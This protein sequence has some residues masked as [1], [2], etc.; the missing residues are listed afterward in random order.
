MSEKVKLAI[1]WH[2]HQPY[3]RDPLS[4]QFEMPWVRLHALRD[5]WGMAAMLEEFPR[6]HVT[7]NLAPSLLSQIEDLVSRPQAD[8]LFQLVFMPVSALT[9]EQKEILCEA[10]FQANYD[11]QIARFPRFLELYQRTH[12]RPDAAA[13]RKAGQLNDQEYLDLQVLSQLCWFD[14]IFLEKDAVIRPLQEKGRLFTEDDKHRVREKEME[15]LSK[16]LP[17]YREMDARNQIEISA[18]PFY[19]PILPLLCDI[20]I[21]QQSQP[22][23]PLPHVAFRHPEDAR[24]Q[25]HRA[26]E[27]HE[28]LFGRPPR[29]MWPSEG[30]VSDEALGILADAGVRW[31]ATDEGVLA[32]TLGLAFQRGSGGE[33]THAQAL[34]SVYQFKESGL[35]I[36]FRDH[37]LSDAIGFFYSRMAPDAAVDDF[38]R[39]VKASVPPESSCSYVSIILDGENAWEFYPEN[40]RPFLRRFY[41]RLSEDPEIEMMTFSEACGHVGDQ[42]R[43]LDSIWPGSWIKADFSVWIGDSE[44]NRSWELLT[45][46]REAY[47]VFLRNNPSRADE[48]RVRR[49]LESLLVAE[50]SDWCWW[51][52]P[53]HSSVNDLRFDRL[54][55]S[56]L[57]HCYQQL[58]LAVPSKLAEPLKRQTRKRFHLSPQVHIHPAIDGLVSSYF[59]WMGAGSVE[60]SGSTMHQDRKYFSALYY[61]WDKEN[62]YLRLDFGPVPRG[63]GELFDVKVIGPQDESLTLK[64]IFGQSSPIA[65][66]RRETGKVDPYAVPDSGASAVFAQILEARFCLSMWSAAADGTLPFHVVIEVNGIPV[67]RIPLQG[68]LVMDDRSLD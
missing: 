9:R 8:P 35:D 6:V 51:Y 53:E 60:E 21:A 68:E 22:R 59:E 1:L 33:L 31:V 40:G 20:S 23:L 17:T 56:H 5:Y 45:E 42:R 58:G 32:K 16:I 14:E 49:A 15:L 2:M 50:G 62:L 26:M 61:G 12:S 10:L 44:D 24:L 37:E 39:R 67:E 30:S 3:Y 57:I 54:F 63:T 29:G 19:H 34:H 13:A 25:V 66:Y 4:G 46:A 48:P 65:I 41:Q 28:R 55:R 43:R 52:G 64:D 18:S 7:F 11:H 47:E 38:I 36:V 27:Q